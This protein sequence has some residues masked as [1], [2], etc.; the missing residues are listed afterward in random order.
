MRE[1]V[2][3]KHNID[4]YSCP[5]PFGS[6]AKLGPQPQLGLRSVGR[7]RSSFDYRDHSGVD[8]KNLAD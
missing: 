6:A 1:H 2:D 5:I 3:A 8:G 4:Y 7:P